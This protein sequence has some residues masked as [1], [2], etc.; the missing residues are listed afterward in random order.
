MHLAFLPGRI[1][2]DT[3]PIT[4]H[5]NKQPSSSGYPYMNDPTHSETPTTLRSIRSRLFESASSWK[6]LLLAL[7]LVMILSFLVQ[8][9]R[10]NDPFTIQDDFQKFFWMHRF[11]DP[12]LFPD[13]LLISNSVKDFELGPL[14]LILDIR[15]PGYSMLFFLASPI[16]PINLFSKL[17]LFP[18]MLVSVYFLFRIGEKIRG[19]GTGFALALVFVVS[20]LGAESSISVTTGL[21][22]AF[23]GPALLGLVYFLMVK[24]YT[25]ALIMVLIGG[26]IYPP[27]LLL[28][29]IV[30][31]LSLFE[32]ADNRWRVR[33]NWR[34][35]LPLVVL[36][37]IALLLLL[38]AVR[39]QLLRIQLPSLQ[40]LSQPISLLENPDFSSGGRFALFENSLFPLVGRAGLITWPKNFWQI[41]TLSLLV[42]SLLLLAPNSW[43]NFPRPLK[44]LLAASFI[45]FGLAWLAVILTSSFVLYLPSRYARV[46]LRLVLLIFVVVN[47]DVSIHAIF[48]LLKQLSI[49]LRWLIVCVIGVVFLAT[50]LAIESGRFTFLSTIQ[51]SEWKWPFALAFCVFVGAILLRFLTRSGVQEGSTAGQSGLKSWQWLVI[52]FLLLILSWI[53]YVQPG[54]KGFIVVSPSVRDMLTFLQTLPKEVRIMGEPCLTNTVPLMAKRSVLWSCESLP[55]GGQQVTLDTLDA[56]YSESM[57]DLF[58]F[59]QRYDIDY[60]LVNK[61][62]FEQESLLSGTIPFEPYRSIMQKKIS[63]QETFAL[64]DIP[65]T[66]IAYENEAIVVMSCKPPVS[67]SSE[68]IA[69]AGIGDLQLVWSDLSSEIAHQEATVKVEL[70][71]EGL[72]TAPEN[73]NVCLNLL[74][75]GNQSP[76]PQCYPLAALE[77]IRQVGDESFALESYNLNVSQYLDSG[78]Y[79]IVAEVDPQNGQPDGVDRLSIGEIQLHALPRVFADEELEPAEIETSWGGKI[80]LTSYTI[81]ETVDD[82]MEIEVNWYALERMTSSYKVFIHLVKAETGELVN[83]LDGMPLNWTYP[84]NWWEKNE[85]ITDTLIMPLAGTDA[86]QYQ[87]WLGLYDGDSNERLFLDQEVIPEHEIYMDAIKI[88][89][90]ER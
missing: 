79:T 26:I 9:P 32:P 54:M 10:I 64:Q 87:I 90:F 13:N 30:Y 1:Q 20:E 45:A 33:V 86:G 60:M 37:G 3:M 19:P 44:L 17:L 56:Y 72:H 35:L 48:A 5:V 24:K 50:I 76:Q 57:P 34:R 69:S 27:A 89:E 65:N 28:G 40:Q 77:H 81:G 21:Q 49:G 29:I 63:D 8:W 22:R 38:P 16:F 55:A 83:Q 23:L 75:S 66:M 4:N 82:M 74:G 71:W 47:L 85:I 12:S 62:S 25:V 18:L 43:A 61:S 73:L 58:R 70:G 78:T 80:A 15:S 53:F 84:T 67:G 6:W 31:V 52:G 68:Y 36:G 11:E 7:L 42:L 2:I 39:M 46:S 51:I 59:C 14:R 88:H 41:A